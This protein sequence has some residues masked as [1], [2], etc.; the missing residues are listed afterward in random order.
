[1][2]ELSKFQITTVIFLLMFVFVIGAIYTNTKE[3]ADK[4]LNANNNAIVQNNENDYDYERN[5]ISENNSQIKD[6]SNRVDELTQQITNLKNTKFQE[7]H[8]NVKCRIF[9]ITTPNGFMQLNQSEAISEAYNNGAD[10]VMTCNFW[11]NKN[12]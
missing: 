9:G 11:L 4:K 1:M 6:L 5:V 2:R 10:L 3:V 7:E 8:S 12:F